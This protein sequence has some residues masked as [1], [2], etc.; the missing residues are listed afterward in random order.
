MSEKPDRWVVN[1]DSC[2]EQQAG[3]RRKEGMPLELH[4]EVTRPTV[5]GRMALQRNGEKTQSA[6][7][8][9]LRLLV[10]T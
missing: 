7:E 10:S 5:G 2:W 1:P 9:M 6:K 3:T 4:G 8:I